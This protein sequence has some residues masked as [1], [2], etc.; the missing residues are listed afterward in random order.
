MAPGSFAGGPAQPDLAAIKEVEALKDAY[1]P[2]PGNHKHR[3]NY[4]FLNVVENPAARV[5]PQGPR[6]GRKCCT[7]VNP[8]ILGFC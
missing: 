6:R 7:S 2:W 1:V 3:F 4:L 8:S 5:K